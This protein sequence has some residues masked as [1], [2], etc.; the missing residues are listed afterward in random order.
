MF[1][2]Y[3]PP[4]SQL[5]RLSP[6]VNDQNQIMAM[7]TIPWKIIGKPDS[8]TYNIITTIKKNPIK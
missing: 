5:T 1:Y 8:K 7:T 3:N 6:A 2:L 4:S